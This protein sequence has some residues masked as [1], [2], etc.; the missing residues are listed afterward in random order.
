M[1]EA[2]SIAYNVR[3]YVPCLVSCVR[4]RIFWAY[5]SCSS[6]ESLSDVEH[7]V[8]VQPKAVCL[9][10]ALY[11]GANALADELVQLLED[12]P[13]FLQDGATKLL[14]H[15]SRCLFDDLFRKTDRWF[16]PA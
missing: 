3:M 16:N 7:T 6:H 14:I 9:I 2:V 5:V 11:E 15:D 4:L 12:L 10:C 1:L 13:R 8:L